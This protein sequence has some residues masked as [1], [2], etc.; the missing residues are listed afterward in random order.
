MERKRYAG[1]IVKC[2]DKILLCKRNHEGSF[3]GMWSVPAGKV[4][5]GENTKEACKREFNEE[6]AIN[7]DNEDINFVGVVPRM[8]RDGSKTKG[9]MY[10]YLL[11]VDEEIE[12]DFEK[13]KDGE[14]HSEFGYFKENQIEENKTGTHLYKLLKIIF[15][16]Y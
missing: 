9:L 5:D 4:E 11:N 7:I 16:K 15:E 2:R 8:S 13:A 12:P 3:P 10:V 14:E 1:L 6:T